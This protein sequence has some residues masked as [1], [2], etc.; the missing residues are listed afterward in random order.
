MGTKWRAL[1]T[2]ARHTRLSIME[3][4][5]S[6]PVKALV[7]FITNSDDSYAR[8]EGAGEIVSGRIYV[9]VL[10]HRGDEDSIL[11]VIDDAEGF[12]DSELEQ[13]FG[14]TGLDTAAK[15]GVAVRGF[16]GDGLKEGVLG[17][18]RGGVLETIKDGL[19]SRAELR[20]NDGRPEFCLHEAAVKATATI[21]RELGMQGNGTQ[22][23]VS[24]HPEIRVPRH[25]R[26]HEQLSR[27]FALRGIVQNP[28]RILLVRRLNDRGKVLA[29]DQASY[30]EPVSDPSFGVVPLRGTLP[31]FGDMP[32]EISLKRS[33]EPLDSEHGPLRENG[34][35][36]RAHRATVDIGFFGL[37]NRL[38]TEH[39]FGELRCD[40]L[41]DRLRAGDVVLT[42]NRSGLNRQ[43]EFVTTLLDRARGLLEPIVAAEAERL[44]GRNSQPI[45]AKARRRLDALRD[46]LNKIARLELE[47]EGDE[48][49]DDEGTPALRFARKG[50]HLHVDEP[51]I[52]RV[53]VRADLAATATTL[54]LTTDGRGLMV[55]PAVVE[56]D[57]GEAREH[58]GVLAFE[59]ELTGSTELDA[60]LVE[61]HIGEHSARATVVV[62]RREQ[63]MPAPPF[64]FEREAYRLPVTQWKE[65]SLRIHVPSVTDLPQEIAFATGG[66][67]EVRPDVVIADRR[68]ARDE[69]IT[70]PI[71]VRGDRIGSSDV[72]E[73]RMGN[74]RATATL[75]VVS[76]ADPDPRPKGGGLIRD[77]QYHV[78]RDPPQRTLFQ[79]RAITIFVNHES[80]SRYLMRPEDREAPAGRA[81]VA[82]LVMHA[83][84]R[85]VAEQSY[86]A[87]PFVTDPASAVQT[88][89]QEYE[90][91]IRKYGQR[92]HSIMNP[93]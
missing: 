31:Q 4:I 40:A 85:Y 65:L 89:F 34:L 47:E 17:L 9:D 29:Q 36:V 35:L 72:L 60:G 63:P 92:L 64:A 74:W 38:G 2:D 49:G 67:V 32:F 80:I 58:H 30:Q 45:D 7:E 56:V 70:V 59:A 42:K 53:L 71:H 51:K 20:W 61:A 43:N 81:L 39:M 19:Y 82:D 8:L 78:R 13:R 41:Y 66:E 18:R 73:A 24:L 75:R 76:A 77:I 27:H 44:K 69:W 26:L 86:A 16:F 12:D 68:D 15:A 91:M 11:R 1:K 90:R 50:Y 25:D 79:D 55:T 3:M 84:C 62:R 10:E 54:R 88:V 14:T 6:N 33:T 52:L 28:A 57:P 93:R 5:Q 48:E 46:E 22:L 23:T 21:R 87:N 37:D 83:F